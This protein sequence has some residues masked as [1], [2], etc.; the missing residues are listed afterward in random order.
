M[1]I[2]AALMSSKS[3][4]AKIFHLVTSEDHSLMDLPWF[5]S[6]HLELTIYPKFL[7][8]GIKLINSN[9]LGVLATRYTT[10]SRVVFT[11]RIFSCCA[12][13][14]NLDL[15]REIGAGERNRTVVCSLEGSHSTIKPHP[16][17]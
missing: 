14:D 4:L 6:N 16:R 11:V 10:K 7:S 12:F 17:G 9:F 5:S 15:G 3:S 2:L 13:W 8:F 1:T